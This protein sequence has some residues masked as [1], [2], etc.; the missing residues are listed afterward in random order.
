MGLA[1]TE[2]LTP[3]EISIEDLRNKTLAVDTYN[4]LYQFLSSIRQADGSLLMDSKG[5]ITSH[6]TGLFNR[7]TRLMG[8][9]MKF[10]FC[11]DGEV[12]ELKHKERER[13]KEVK[14]EAQKK[15]EEAAKEENLEDMKKFAARTSR[16]TSEMIEDAK[17][18]IKALGQCIVEAPSEG[19]AQASF[20][21]K[22]GDADYVLSQD[23]DCFMFC[24]P[25]LVKN[26]TIS[27][28]RKKPGAY[29]YDE[30]LPEVI[31]LKD[32]LEELGINQEQLIILGIL[33]GTD[34]NIGGIKGIGPKKALTLI[35][36]HGND[37]EAIFNEV[38]WSENFDFSW[39][40][41]FDLIKNM[42]VA[43]NYKL[44][45]EPVDKEKVIDILVNQHD[46]SK[47]RV[48]NSLAKLEQSTNK[49]QK[50]LG[51]FF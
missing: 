35:K 14:I 19:E 11:F 17:E 42:K 6:L 50:G 44:K 36:K 5:R 43:E 25:K 48:E 39:Y 12:P 1:I 24:A 15:F 51:D 20:I 30:V 34:Y 9:N 37:Y 3:K 22:K 31:H 46:F 49:R 4:L 16:L 8:Y 7:I 18:L 10:I 41:V 38:K 45:W 2:I 26:L 40:K 47:E 27:G 23:A 13:R 29:A 32:V 28:K 33:V 21:V